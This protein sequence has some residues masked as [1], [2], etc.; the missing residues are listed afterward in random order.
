M[1][2]AILGL[3]IGTNST[4]AVLFDCSG[5]E[6]ASAEQSYPL[7]TPA[8]G[9]A[10]QDP[11]R[12]WQAVIRAIQ[13]VVNDAGPQVHILAL[14]V[15]AQSGS[16][17]PAS[18]AGTPVY[19]MITWLDERTGPLV[20]Q[21]KA[22]GVEPNVRRI[23]GWLLHPGLPLPNI[24]WL[25]QHR[26]DIFAEAER[27]LGVTDYVNHRLTGRFV[28]DLSS[29]AEMQLVEA[30]SGRWSRQLCDLAGITPE[31]LSQL[32]PAGRAIGRMKA[33][34][35][36]VT[37]LPDQ[38]IVV[39]G[40]HD[41]CCTAMAM[42]ISA[43]GRVMLSCGTAWVIT[44]V[45]ES[46][47]VETI[48]A[49]MD[50]NFHVVPE[51]WTVSQLLGGFGATLEWWLNQS[52]QGVDPQRASTRAELYTAFNRGLEL[53]EP[54]S[55]GLLFL[56]LG[57]GSQLVSD[58]VRGG[59]VGL[60]LDHTR[61]TMGRAVLEGTAYEV[62][63][64][65]ENIRRAGLPVEQLFLVGGATRSLLW[66]QILAD[67]V[68]V[69]LSVSTYTRWPALGAAILAGAGAGVFRSIEAGQ[70]LFRKGFET[71]E[72]DESRRRVYDAGYAEYKQLAQ[73]LSEG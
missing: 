7:S 69:P 9:W 30:S 72:P 21:W 65:V 50:L 40:G 67:V 22:G 32:E 18:A 16:V 52:W 10:E 63:W 54:G 25:R 39:N 47:A 31:Q 58:Q 13:A 17:I 56:P 73:L 33:E 19:P 60:R 36:R 3:D 23:S 38:T 4:K 70:E 5:S 45:V 71:I 46:P 37:G 35:A 6:V 49:N 28:A 51:R 55:R 34:V 44:T 53:T 15:A 1:V 42:G 59:F 20:D 29:G 24:A 48:P 62:R 61:A 43:P 41:Q 26:A 27:F 2:D 8:A 11:E 64:G 68:G 66:T 12:L 57:G 14:A